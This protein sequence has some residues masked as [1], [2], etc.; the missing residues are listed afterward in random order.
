MV[1]NVRV[2]ENL[3]ENCRLAAFIAEFHHL[4]IVVKN[5]SFLRG[6]KVEYIFFSLDSIFRLR[7]NI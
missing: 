3:S 4:C 6:N 1:W 2:M 5:K 7:F